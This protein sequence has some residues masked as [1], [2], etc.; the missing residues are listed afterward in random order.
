MTFYF[1]KAVLAWAGL[2]IPSVEINDVKIE[3]LANK[4]SM[5]FL[6]INFLKE[7]N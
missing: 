5:S 2:I 1:R 7:E 3:E 4:L 6:F